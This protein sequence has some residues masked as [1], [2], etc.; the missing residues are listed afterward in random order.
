MFDLSTEEKDLWERIKTKE[1]LRPIFFRKARGLKWF[2][3]MEIEGF[4]NPE[5]NPKPVPAKEEG[6]INVPVWPITEY[7]VSSSPEL[8]KEENVDYARRFLDII[9]SVTKYAMTHGY[10]NYRTWWKFSKIIPHIPSTLI[11]KEFVNIVEYWLSDPYDRSLVAGQVGETWLEELLN[12]EDAH[13]A[14]LALGL[15]D[16]L[17]RV[18]FSERD[19]G[20]GVKKVPQ[21]S[22][23]SYYVKEIYTKVARK[24]GK[25]LGVNAVKFFHKNLT[26][27]LAQL[28]NDQW[29][30]IWR[31][32]IEDH[33]QNHGGND[34]EDIV[35]QG[36]RDA[37]LG[38][39]EATPEEAKQY[40]T[41]LLD[42]SYETIKRIAI[43][44]VDQRFQCLDSLADLII[45]SQYFTS[46]FRHEL[47]HFLNNHYG[48][49]NPEQ[50][51]QVIT[52][53]SGLTVK[54]E[55]GNIRDG[56]SAYQRAIWLSAIKQYGEKEGQLYNQSIETGGARPENPDFSS[57]SSGGWVG[58]KSPI[59][60]E[61]LR[62]L[63]VEDLT[64]RLNSYKDPGRFVEPG[65]EGLVKCFR[66][67]VKAEPL[68]F[69]DQLQNFVDSDLAFIYEVI[70][71]YMELWNEKASLPW[72]DIWDNILEF[73][74]QLVKQERFWAQENE[75]ERYSFV[76]NRSWVVGGIGRLIEAGTKSDDHAFS[77]SLSKKAE[78]ILATVLKKE[79]GEEFQIGSDAVH[80]A[81]N[82]PRGKCLEGLI[83]LCLRSCR[84]SDKRHGNHQEAW[85]QFQQYFDS[86]ISR[87]ENGEYEFITLAIN[88]L[89]NFLYMSNDWTLSNLTKIF[90]QT[91]YQKWLCAMQ[92]YAYVNQVYEKIYM[93]LKL[94]GDLVK[95]LDDENVADEVK[96]KV[97][98]NISV[99]YIEGIENLN[100]KKS[101]ILMLIN[102]SKYCELSQLIWFLWA[103][104]KTADTGYRDKIIELWSQIINVTNSNTKEGKKIFSQLC[105]WTTFINEVNDSNRALIYKIAPYAGEAYKTA[106]LLKGIA[107]ISE[108]QPFE[109]F[110]IFMQLL[111]GSRPDYPQEAFLSIF[112]NLCREGSEGLR[113][114]KEI[115]DQYIKD[116]NDQ[117]AQ[118]LQDILDHK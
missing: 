21:F 63:E 111:K 68:R 8:S 25:N 16:I 62:S 112:E 106:D 3:Y 83:N 107:K 80:I 29:S 85:S 32:A 74:D 77:E 17:S 84:L 19:Y 7:L 22:F 42:D 73:C 1:E 20:S 99:M 118:W 53:I 93:H 12:R 81:I 108:H 52:I 11:E 76:A 4:F 6:F 51:G 40:I 30:S 33:D 87:A 104:R 65:L 91:K 67:L 102:R 31:S 105:L 34:V 56:V 55:S 2:D 86:E 75:K 113:K 114:A 116:G 59:P 96:D 39:S 57:Y 18:S 44:I 9:R 115:V 64:I 66:Q 89:P 72:N 49:L 35:I 95:A 98:Q 90:D 43:Y 24:A 69:Y 97:I 71:A 45:E 48:E 5:A 38:Y 117:P 78:V 10:S 26:M 46:N 101:L 60:I 41:E 37:F 13:S 109:A 103:L 15:L 50:K 94:N 14:T 36:Y 23:D 47:W 28:G 58:H 88:Y 92:G 110:E 27:I 82:S 79:S 70:E 100:D 54:D 61:E